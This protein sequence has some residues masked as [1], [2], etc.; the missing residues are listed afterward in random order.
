STSITELRLYQKSSSQSDSPNSRRPP[1]T[2]S[3]LPD[4]PEARSALHP[5]QRRSRTTDGAWKL[6]AA[7]PRTGVSVLRS[8]SPHR[9]SNPGRDKRVRVQ[10]LAIAPLQHRRARSD[11]ECPSAAAPPGRKPGHTPRH[12]Q[13]RPK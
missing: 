7:E 6:P 4:K 13:S 8:T 9:S 1:K 11:G 5:K 3:G 2:T 10:A 12:A